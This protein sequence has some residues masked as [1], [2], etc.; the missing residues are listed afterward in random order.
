MWKPD[1]APH[2]EALDQD[3][4][5]AFGLENLDKEGLTHFGQGDHFVDV[6]VLQ[7]IL[8]GDPQQSGGQIEQVHRTALC[9]D[10]PGPKLIWWHLVEHERLFVRRIIYFRLEAIAMSHAR[11]PIL[12]PSGSLTLRR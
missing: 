8:R 12:E 3:E 9:L 5:S 4:V 6:K 11:S 7:A 1:N 2:W 10:E